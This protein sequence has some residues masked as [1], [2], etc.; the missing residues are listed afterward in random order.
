MVILLTPRQ[1]QLLNRV[2]EE[3]I[4]TAEPVS[5]K[6]I[7]SGGQFDVRSA[8]IRNE[9]ADMEDVGLLAQLHTSGG[10]VPTAKAYRLYVNSLIANEGLAVSHAMRRRVD[11]ALQGIDHKDP[12]TVNKTL[13]RIIGEL[14]GNLVMAN[15]SEREDAYKVGLSNMLTFPE[16]REIDRVVGLTEFFDQFE[17]MFERMHRSMWDQHDT[18]TKVMIGSESPYRQV[19]DET[20]IVSRYRLPKGHQGTLTLVGPMRMDYRKNLG[21]MTYAAQI[22]NRI[23]DTYRA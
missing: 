12:E 5:S 19:H 8:T 3:Y 22:A 11:E 17:S 1:V 9:M 7:E 4:A 2:I 13:A 10:R 18:D 23:T 15:M 6:T 21:L 14:S 20:V 16:F